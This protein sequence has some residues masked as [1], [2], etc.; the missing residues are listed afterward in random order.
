MLQFK[1][2]AHRW[3]LR[4]R[5]WMRLQG[6]DFTV[7]NEKGVRSDHSKMPTFPL[8]AEDSEVEELVGSVPSAKKMKVS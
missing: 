6:E 2:S 3:K 4:P 1:D 5:M 8:Q 7:R